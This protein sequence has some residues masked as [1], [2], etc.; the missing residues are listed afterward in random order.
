MRIAILIAITAVAITVSTEMYASATPP[1]PQPTP[2]PYSY[3]HKIR[4][5]AGT[6]VH[7]MPRH[8]YRECAHGAGF[9]MKLIG[10]GRTDIECSG[11]VAD[12]KG[13]GPVST[14][15][16]CIMYK[17]K[18]SKME[19]ELVYEVGLPVQAVSIVPPQYGG[20]KEKI[21]V[22]GDIKFIYL[23]DNCKLTVE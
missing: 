11:E 15:I 7:G 6:P 18:D 17:H 19:H 12:H 14:Y 9:K 20:R 22:S 23:N 5:T 13:Y 8:T 2:K 1:R 16:D 10:K 3:Q 21:Q 4:L